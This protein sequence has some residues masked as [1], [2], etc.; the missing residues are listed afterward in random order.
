MTGDLFTQVYPEAPGFSNTDTSIAA[1]E[2]TASK[3]ATLRSIVLDVF[4]DYGPLTADE[5]A[6]ILGDSILSI[7]PR[8]TELNRMGEIEDAGTRRKNISGRNAIVWAVKVQ[9][10]SALRQPEQA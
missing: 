10:G 7:R 6:E 9:N 1:A 8:V 5:V 2:H 3:A 4:S